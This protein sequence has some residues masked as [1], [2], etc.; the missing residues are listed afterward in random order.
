MIVS[1]RNSSVSSMLV[2]WLESKQLDSV[3]LVS[4]TITTEKTVA[5]RPFFRYL[6]RATH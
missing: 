1:A 2:I 4:Y 5:C 3:R 6:A